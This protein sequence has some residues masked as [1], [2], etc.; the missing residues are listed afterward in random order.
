MG[1][2]GGALGGVVAAAVCAG[3]GAGFAALPPRSFIATATQQRTT[4]KPR[5]T[6]TIIP[7]DL[8]TGSGAG[9]T[10]SESSMLSGVAISSDRIAGSGAFQRSISCAASS[11]VGAPSPI[12]VLIRFVGGFSGAR[13][14]ITASCSAATASSPAST[15]TSSVALFASLLV[16]TSTLATVS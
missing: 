15:S 6:F 10:S 8:L 16:G 12:C 3:A 5:T 7:E 1:A 11:A 2:G 14:S 13:S 4:A 9:S